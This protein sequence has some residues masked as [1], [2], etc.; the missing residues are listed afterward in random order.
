MGN[1][2]RAE[3]ACRSFAN[4][5]DCPD[6]PKAMTRRRA[7]SQNALGNISSGLRRYRQAIY[8]Y[9]AQFMATSACPLAG[10]L[11]PVGS[12][13]ESWACSTR[14]CCGR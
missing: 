14:P 3:G 1:F 9:G 10:R 12:C 7:S 6:Q 13:C 2:A 4:P 11:G 5:V 8:Y